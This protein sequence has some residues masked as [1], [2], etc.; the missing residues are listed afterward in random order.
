MPGSQA[1]FI[2]RS[3]MKRYALVFLAA[4]S[5]MV[6]LHAV[7]AKCDTYTTAYS[8]YR[9]PDPN[10]HAWISVNT[11]MHGLSAYDPTAG[12][13]PEGYFLPASPGSEP[14]TL[15]K[16]FD[17][18][19]QWADYL[20]KP[21]PWRTLNSERKF[22]SPSSVA[23]STP[24]YCPPLAACYRI[25]YP[26]PAMN[27][28]VN[29]SGQAEAKYLRV[30]GETTASAFLQRNPPAVRAAETISIKNQFTVLP[31]TTSKT[32]NDTAQLTISFRLEGTLNANYNAH[33]RMNG[34]ISVTG[35]AQGTAVS[36]SGY[37]NLLTGPIFTNNGSISSSRSLSYSTNAGANHN[38]NDNVSNSLYGF[39][40]GLLTLNFNALVGTTYDVNLSLILLSE[41]NG[42]GN[43][44]AS[45]TQF[46]NGLS[47]SII[48]TDGTF[49]SWLIAPMKGDLDGNSLVD[50]TDEI[51]A[52]QTLAGMKPAGILADFAT[53]GADVN[54]D[55]KIGMEEAIYIMQ[56][57]AGMR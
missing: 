19:D 39:D 11:R 18:I 52:L 53:S 15:Q 44:G 48:S 54:N 35:G 4:V 33:S 30:G 8:Y 26:Y 57:V 34:D 9:A 28:L 41:A 55:N 20:N 42:D 24:N 38:E 7:D 22:D 10:S 2:G 23:F 13:G 27:P 56:K 3:E 45:L 17:E 50:L 37:A 16:A 49:V 25:I 6:L 29:V 31:G 12:T 14:A 47:A 51:L 36:V 1:G 5:V 43:E 40:T 32:T 46:S 21:L